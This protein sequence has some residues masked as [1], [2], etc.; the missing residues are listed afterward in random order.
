[1]V[2][3]LSFGAAVRCYIWLPT[4]GTEA[5]LRIYRPL[6]LA[7][8]NTMGNYSRLCGLSDIETFILVQTMVHGGGRFSDDW[9]FNVQSTDP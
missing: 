5:V 6:F 3:F 1:M 4:T 9:S 2:Y 8:P 7:A